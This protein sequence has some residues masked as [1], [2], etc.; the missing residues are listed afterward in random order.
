MN[1]AQAGLSEVAPGEEGMG[2]SRGVGS[3]FS[4]DLWKVS[5]MSRAMGG[6][7]R[8]RGANTDETWNM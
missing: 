3:T 2:C 5:E 8:Y 4:A 1:C 6:A 7:E